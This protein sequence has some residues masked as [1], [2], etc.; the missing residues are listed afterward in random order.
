MEGKHFAFEL[1]ENLREVIVSPIPTP[2]YYT[3][4]R[5]KVI[6]SSRYHLKR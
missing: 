4:P 6:Y 1:C 2:L 3:V 5:T